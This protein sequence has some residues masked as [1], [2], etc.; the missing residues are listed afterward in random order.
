MQGGFFGI[1]GVF[2][3]ANNP[4]A[5]GFGSPVQFVIQQPDFDLLVKG[6]DTLLARARQVKGLSTWTATSGSTSR[7]SP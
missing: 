7:S 6:N 4:P 5:F 2:A 1:P 3:F